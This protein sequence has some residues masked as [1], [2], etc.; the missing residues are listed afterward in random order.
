MSFINSIIKAFVGDKSEKD[1]KATQPY[2]TKIKALEPVLAALSHDDLRAK[3]S[4]FKEKI[5]QARAKQDAEIEAKKIEAENTADIDLREDIYN[6]IDALEKEAYEIS[7]KVLMEILPEAFAVIKETA[8]RFKEN[9]TITVTSSEKDRELSATKPYIT[10]VGDQTNWSNQ[11]NAAGKQI[12]WDMIHYDVQLI[13]GIV[14]HEGKISEMQ[15]GEGKTL[16]ATLPLYL[17]ALT[18]MAF[19]W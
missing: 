5:K 10:L 12:T 3:T 17:N 14:L 16:V 2:I 18:E 7:E 15:T 6:A 11:W 4:E 19:I 9:S 1:V 13:G 8:K